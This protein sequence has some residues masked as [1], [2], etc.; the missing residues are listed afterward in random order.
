MAGHGLFKPNKTMKQQT[1][2]Y[3]CH[4]FICTKSRNGTRKSCE[5]A[6]SADLKTKIK[7]ELK[8]RGWKGLVRVSDSG[9]LGVCE[10]G[11]NIMIYPQKIWFN[12]VTLDDLPQI[13]QTLEEIV[14]PLASAE[15]NK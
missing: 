2:P 10:E 3:K 13:I 5:D 8:Q 11:P 9:C 15:Q 6:G 7:A 1:A 4:L 12:S 14:T